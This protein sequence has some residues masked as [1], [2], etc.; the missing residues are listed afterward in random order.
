MRLFLPGASAVRGSSSAAQDLPC[1]R[2][3]P[4]QRR[5]GAGSARPIILPEAVDTAALAA[6]AA[7]LTGGTTEVMLHPGT[8]NDVLVR[9][10][11]WDHDFAAELAAVCA[12]AVQDAIAAA[13][14]APVNF[15]TYAEG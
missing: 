14:A 6:I 2:I 1:S 12:P 13:G 10:C 11:R 7:H 9:D 5:I 8:D 15:R 3:A 4:Q